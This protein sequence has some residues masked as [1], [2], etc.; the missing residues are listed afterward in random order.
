MRLAMSGV[1]LLGIG[2]IAG[3][4][5]IGALDW[6]TAVVIASVGAAM[7]LVGLICILDRN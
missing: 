7:A 5:S 6:I 4:K 1:V 2:V 3:P